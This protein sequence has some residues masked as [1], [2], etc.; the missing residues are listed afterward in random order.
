[1]AEEGR[2]EA[3]SRT[4]WWSAADQTQFR[5]WLRVYA[6]APDADVRAHAQ[7]QLAQLMLAGDRLFLL[8]CRI[9]DYEERWEIYQETLVHA[10]R[11]LPW[12]WDRFG[13]QADL[14]LYLALCLRTVLARRALQ[15]VL[16]PLPAESIDPTCDIETQVAHAEYTVLLWDLTTDLRAY[17]R[18]HASRWGPHAAAWFEALYLAGQSEAALARQARVSREHVHRTVRKILLDPALM[19]WLEDYFARRLGCRLQDAL[20][21]LETRDPRRNTPVQPLFQ[22]LFQWRAIYEDQHHA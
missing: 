8:T 2:E 5:T 11:R 19:V 13:P 16:V 20:R 15:P 1:M 21:A 6:E 7:T 9:R 22:A 3:L 14:A 18:A 12:L 10:L 4:S 17:V